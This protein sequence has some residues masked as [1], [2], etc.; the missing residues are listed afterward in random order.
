MV[1]PKLNEYLDSLSIPFSA[2]D[3]AKVLYSYLRRIELA[4]DNLPEGSHFDFTDLNFAIVDFHAISREFD[5]YTAGLLNRL[6]E[7]VPW[8]K[9]WMGDEI[10]FRIYDANNKYRGLES[11]FLYQPGLNGHD[12]FM[13]IVSTPGIST[14]Y[15]GATYS[16]LVES[17]E[18][19]DL[20]NA[21][22]CL[23]V[24]DPIP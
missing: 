11:I 18:A 13:Y 7:H 15:S 14:G 6:G 12:W 4:A 9:R 22:V 8:Y 3:Y 10:D 5:D 21:K 17:L 19:G 1:P 24:R 23:F 16:G 2:S 20:E